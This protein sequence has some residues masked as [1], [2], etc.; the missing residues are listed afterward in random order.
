[1]QEKGC[2][3]ECRGCPHCRDPGSA[4]KTCIS[5]AFLRTTICS[6]PLPPRSNI[7]SECKNSTGSASAAS[8]NAP[9]YAEWGEAKKAPLP[10]DAY[11]PL[12]SQTYDSSNF[13]QMKAG[14]ICSSPLVP[15]LD[16]GADAATQH[17]RINEVLGLPK[18]HAHHLELTQ[19][20][21]KAV[22]SF[23]GLQTV[24]ENS[25]W[26]H[27]AREIGH[28]PEDYARLRMYYVIVCYPYEQVTRMKIEGGEGARTVLVVYMDP[29]RADI[30]PATV[31]ALVNK[32]KKEGAVGYVKPVE[33]SGVCEAVCA[34]NYMKRNGVER[35]EDLFELIRL[36]ERYRC[37][38]REVADVFSCKEI[39]LLKEELNQ[40]VRKWIKQKIT[41]MKSKDGEKEKKVIKMYETY[42]IGEIDRGGGAG[43]SAG[44]SGDAGRSDD[45]IVGSALSDGGSVDASVSG[46]ALSDGAIGDASVNCNEIDKNL[47]DHP[48][49]PHPP[50][51]HSA[52]LPLFSTCS[53]C[54]VRRV[55]RDPYLQHYAA[56]DFLS[57]SASICV[58][59]E[60]LFLLLKV[61]RDIPRSELGFGCR[62]VGKVLLVVWGV[63]SSG[64]SVPD[65]EKLRCVAEEA[66]SLLLSPILSKNGIISVL[67]GGE[68]ELVLRI[69]ATPGGKAFIEVPNRRLAQIWR[70]LLVLNAGGH[71]SGAYLHLR[72][73]VQA[74]LD[75]LST[76]LHACLRSPSCTEEERGQILGYLDPEGAW[77]TDVIASDTLSSSG[78]ALCSLVFGSS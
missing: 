35:Q 62:W 46:S 30:F 61:L 32:K 72:E 21:L 11:N 37:T 20:I 25:L 73:T 19:K 48:P 31:G 77:L 26:L 69:L 60:T 44:G 45:A 58:G 8:K 53:E 3:A 74:S 23:G 15:L 41:K 12:A 67:A 43:S 33:T 14:R 57:K 63:V 13:T 18:I 49:H 50:H 70:Y 24:D 51:S 22:S 56:L 71:F 29:K 64:E 42:L 75:L 6:R 40:I 54:G 10:C 28:Q 27:V 17:L 34:L 38:N 59:S 66:K 78:Y 36:V 2:S 39:E 7:L 52:R 1:M 9:K 4:R 5:D 55:F 47:P 16:L 76:H 68:L 65:D